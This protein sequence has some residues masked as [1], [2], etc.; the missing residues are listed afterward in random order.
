MH[1]HSPSAARRDERSIAF[2]AA[3]W[4][5]VAGLCVIAANAWAMGM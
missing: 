4:F 1:T 3:M 5:I 2:A